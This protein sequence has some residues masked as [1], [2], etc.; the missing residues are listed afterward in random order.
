MNVPWFFFQL[1]S[2]GLQCTAFQNHDANLPK[3]SSSSLQTSQF[4]KCHFP[5]PSKENCYRTQPLMTSSIR[6]PFYYDELEKPRREYKD[7]VKTWRIA[8]ATF[9][10]CIFIFRPQIDMGLTS[11]WS[12]LMRSS[13]LLPRMFRHDHWEWCLAVVSFFIWIHGFWICDF[14]CI[15]SEKKGIRHPLRRYRLQDQWEEEKFL[16]RKEKGGIMTDTEPPMKEFAPWHLQAWIFEVPLYCLPLYIWDKLI[17]RRA[18]KL[19]VLSAPSLFTIC[20]DVTLGLLL[21]DC[22]FFICHYIFHKIPFFFQGIS[23]QTSY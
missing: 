10:S 18:A 23:C 9:L 12:Y 17:P 20:R 21:Y 14:L 19:A 11:F 2:L 8:A 7:E 5:F 1:L 13:H 15:K 22:G 16:I 4:I 6:I 3:T